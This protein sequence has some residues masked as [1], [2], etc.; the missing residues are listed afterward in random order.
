MFSGWE[1]RG[2]LRG[3]SHPIGCRFGCL[4]GICRRNRCLERLFLVRGG[5]FRGRRRVDL[6]REEGD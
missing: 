2:A 5:R 6:V 4:V 3:G 1:G